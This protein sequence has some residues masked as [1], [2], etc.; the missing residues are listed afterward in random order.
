MFILNL[1]FIYL[2]YFKSLFDYG[3]INSKRKSF[4]RTFKDLNFS[5]II[6]LG[7]IFFIAPSPDKDKS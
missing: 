2:F 6:I 5:G 7:A 1:L 3:V 4:V